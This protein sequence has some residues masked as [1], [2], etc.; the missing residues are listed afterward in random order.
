MSDHFFT[1][2]DFECLDVYEAC[3]SYRH[4]PITPQEDVVIA[5]R[6]LR[7]AFANRVNVVLQKLRD[8]AT[9]L[10]YNIPPVSYD[11]G[12][13]PGKAT[14]SYLK[15]YVTPTELEISVML[16]DIEKAQKFFKS[17]D[18]LKKKKKDKK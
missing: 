14:Q 6:D 2:D 15:H 4:T 17:N 8:E 11:A 9:P 12:V 10:K 1:A 13:V 16:K 18:E 7:Q 5:Y 3:Q